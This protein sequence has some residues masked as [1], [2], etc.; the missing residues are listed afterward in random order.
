MLDVVC[1]RPPP[2]SRS[3]SHR[4]R[5]RRGCGQTPR[6]DCPASGD[7]RVPPGSSKGDGIDIGVLRMTLTG[8]GDSIRGD[9]HSGR[10]VRDA[11]SMVFRECEYND[12]SDFAFV[13]DELVLPSRPGGNRQR[14]HAIFAEIGTTELRGFVTSSQAAWD[15]VR[16][17]CQLKHASAEPTI[18]IMAN[19]NWPEFTRRSVV[20]DRQRRLS[21]DRCHPVLHPIDAIDGAI[22]PA[23]ATSEVSDLLP[24][25][26]ALGE[27]AP[28]R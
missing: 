5:A 25:R 15:A 7:D 26:L 12:A 3:W 11:N 22:Q 16:Q 10:L 20:E 23:F 2:I 24:C 21:K 17:R 28:E 9:A 8:I 19:D 27:A 18:Y 1:A 14:A 6:A 4:D 13:R